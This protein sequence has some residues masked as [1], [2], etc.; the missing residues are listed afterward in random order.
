MSKSS[1]MNQMWSMS[2]S[3]FLVPPVVLP[4]SL[5]DRLLP[6]KFSIGQQ[7]V[8]AKTQ[9]RDYGYVIGIF[10][11][12]EASVQAVGYHYAIQLAP[13]SPSKQLGIDVDWGFEADLALIDPSGML[14]PCSTSI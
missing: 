2:N 9:S 4:Q 1:S 13:D 12:A 5:P 7:V 11:A 10:Y 8:W 14:A 6:P 3:F